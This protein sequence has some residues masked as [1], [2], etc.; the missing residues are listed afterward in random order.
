LA[1][2]YKVPI[3]FV[4]PWIAAK[5]MTPAGICAVRTDEASNNVILI[6]G[7]DKTGHFSPMTPKHLVYLTAHEIAKAFGA[8]PDTTGETNCDSFTD[9]Q[10]Q[11][12]HYLLWPDVLRETVLAEK[13]FSPCSQQ[14]IQKSLATCKS[15]CFDLNQHPFCGNGTDWYF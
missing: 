1:A 13:A 8:S 9:A 4:T 11:T 15:S 7:N 2:C 3:T 6:S 10:G 5:P 14:S 12:R